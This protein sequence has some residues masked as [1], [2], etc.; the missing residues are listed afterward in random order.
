[1]STGAPTDPCGS[2]GEACTLCP[3]GDTCLA[4]GCMHATNGDCSPANCNGCC[5]NAS[6][7]APGGGMIGGS[8][9][10]FDG[11]QDLYCGSG[12]T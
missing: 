7:P 3:S 9:E 8:S 2:N 4:G 11:T 1:M 10:C 6:M 12:G 5:F